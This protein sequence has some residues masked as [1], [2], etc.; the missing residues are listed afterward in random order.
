MYFEN[1]PV[2]QTNEIS[3]LEIVR[4]HHVYFTSEAFLS[5]GFQVFINKNEHYL[6]N[7]EMIIYTFRTVYNHIERLACKD[8]T[9]DKA[10]NAL[11]MIQELER[12]GALI[13]DNTETNNCLVQ[14]S[15]LEQVLNKRK[16]EII[17]IVT[18]NR[19][20]AHDIL[21]M[22]HLKSCTGYEVYCFD[23]SN[24][25]ALYYYDEKNINNSQS[26][27]YC[28]IMQLLTSRKGA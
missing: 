3:P 7:K 12:D 9:A 1:K 23:L 16:Y 28:D 25:G 24:G 8:N 13:I 10:R 27:A 11:M 19:K 5:S 21:M 20:M 2:M 26:V 17:G 15:V 18:C 6:R 22:N 14:Q 4:N